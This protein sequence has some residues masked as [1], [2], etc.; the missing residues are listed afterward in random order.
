MD[1]TRFAG[2]GQTGQQVVMLH[3]V[4]IHMITAIQD[5]LAFG[6]KAAADAA[7]A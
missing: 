6:T 2:A 1:A 4:D 5:L 3:S 7:C